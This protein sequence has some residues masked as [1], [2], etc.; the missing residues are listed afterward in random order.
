MKMPLKSLR[1]MIS[2]P[3]LLGQ[4]F[5]GMRHNSFSKERS[6][7]GGFPKDAVEQQPV[8]RPLAQPAMGHRKKMI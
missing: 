6:I 2:T 5:H 7:R 8:S 3:H 1:K 4:Q